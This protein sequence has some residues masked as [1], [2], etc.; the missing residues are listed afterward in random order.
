MKVRAGAQA[1]EATVPLME[2][3]GY[4]T[5]FGLGRKGVLRIAWNLTDTTKCPSK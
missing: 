1:I 3:F 4:A 5:D 2:M